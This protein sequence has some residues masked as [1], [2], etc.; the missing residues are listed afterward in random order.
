MKLGIEVDRFRLSWSS[1][2]HWFLSRLFGWLLGRPEPRIV[3]ESAIW[4]AGVRELGR[5]TLGRRRESGA[6]LIGEAPDRGPKIIRAFVFYDDI[7]EHAL[8]TGIVRFNGNHLPKLWEL[9]SEKGLR[10][11][12]DIHV[13]PGG[14]G[15]S[16]SDRAD[17]VMP[18]AGHIAFI[19]P[20]FAAGKV[21]PGGIG[22]YEY[23]GNGAWVDHSRASAPFLELR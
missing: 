16:A 9:C 20:D 13:H 15:Q 2:M 21:D 12:A 8:E 18:R 17:P 19:L 3:C 10:V 1:F 4:A 14:Y 11:V 23:R 5:R 22:Q 6:F 7:D